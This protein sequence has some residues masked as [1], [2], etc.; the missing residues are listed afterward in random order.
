MSKVLVIGADGQLGREIKKIRKRYRMNLMFTDVDLL[1]ATSLKE[2]KNYLAKHPADYLINCAA[3]TDVDAA[4][5][6]EKEAMRINRGIP[7]NLSE[8][9][10]SER[11]L[12]VIHISTDYVFPGDLA[13]PLQEDDPT[14]PLSVYGKSKL[15][16]ERELMGHPRALIIRTSWLYSVFGHNFVKSMIQRMK[17]RTD[18]RIVYDQIG[19]P[20]SAEDLAQAILQIISDVDSDMLAFE[21]G[22]FHYSNSGVCS[23]YDFAMEIC[24]LIGCKTRIIPIESS[25]FPQPAR[26]P[27]YSVLN[28]SLIQEVYG[29]KVPHWRQSL[30]TCIHNLL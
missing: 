5:K 6:N 7:A 19:T 28:K 8:L 22:V 16:G 25:G 14:G 1:D 2:L 20:T 24:R 29:V 10:D 11:S 30:E 26:R 4:E 12:R 21:A 3:Y 27:L 9:M 18:L 13:R 17:Q 23:W 15:A